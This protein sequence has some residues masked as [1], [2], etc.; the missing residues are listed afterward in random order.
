MY[1]EKYLREI[2]FTESTWKILGK[3]SKREAE[4]TAFL[5][6]GVVTGHV[7]YIRAAGRGDNSVRHA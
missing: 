2:L 5:I 7:S 6:G 3:S 1:L 4:N